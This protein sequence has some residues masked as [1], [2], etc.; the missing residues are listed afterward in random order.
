MSSRAPS[1]GVRDLL[2]ALPEAAVLT[3]V[4][5]VPAFF[6]LATVRIFEEEKAL[7]VRAGALLILAGTIGSWRKWLE[8]FR[9]PVVGAC[10][11]LTLAFALS[12][13]TAL[14][15]RDALLGA[16]LR[17]H[18]LVTWLALV[19]TFVGACQVARSEVG[20]GRLVTA[21][22]VGSVW[23]CLY[24]LMQAAGA[25][26]ISWTDT[27]PGR[28]AGTIGNPLFLAGYL[29][30]VVPIT[31][32]RAVGSPAC[33]ACVL[34]Q[35]A[36][37]AATGSRGPALALGAAVLAGVVVLQIRRW[38][39]AMTLAVGI[40]VVATAAVTWVPELRPAFAGQLLDTSSG[41]GRV[42]VLIWRGIRELMPGSGWR[43]WLGYGPESLRHVFPPHY[44]PEIGRIEQSEA[45]PDRA[46]N[47]MLDSLVGAGL[48][49]VVCEVAFL[50]AVLAAAWRVRDR[51]WRGG[52]LAA[53]VAHILEIQL[54]IATVT[55]RLAFLL[56]AALAVGLQLPQQDDG[57]RGA[58][59]AP[60]PRAGRDV[61]ALV[62]AA[63]VS[64]ASPL[65]ARIAAGL[66]G[67]Q[68][69]GDSQA[70]A[71]Y[72]NA[73]AS[74]PPMLYGAL[75][76]AAVAVAW[77]IATP[78]H[79]R[80]PVWPR[81]TAAGVALVVAYVFPVSASRADVMARAGAAF[82]RSGQVREAVVAHRAAN[83][84]HPG[85]EAY[86]TSL[87]RALVQEA[88]AQDE[89]ARSARF[90]EARAI[91]ER[92]RQRNPHSP[93]P[94]RNL[95]SLQRVR[96]QRASPESR[97]RLLEEADR[98]YQDAT[99]RSPGLPVLWTEWANLDAERR[100]FDEALV[101]L[102]R[103]IELDP[104]PSDP[105]LLRGLV[106]SLQR[107]F[108]PALVDYEQ[109]LA[110]SPAALVALRGRAVALAELGRRQ[111]A[112]AALDEVLRVSPDDSAGRVLRD[113]LAAGP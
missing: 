80:I 33:A 113:R 19:V 24:A 73:L 110:R 34:L 46:H 41:S 64:A 81:A 104:G 37:L 100:R 102:Q 106:F 30:V 53:A 36:A 11:V 85:E 82:E 112:R 12:T 20:R 87:G 4:A 70:L 96:A 25:D 9:H 89:P 23:P 52:L 16:Y 78:G 83:R 17:R 29:V 38:R 86:L 101:K 109:A 79:A 13:L 32:V 74:A 14:E 94:P 40:I 49:G 72:L 93:Y 91:L 45:M 7:L 55:S 18:G 2:D 65:V 54:G 61:Q 88:A 35:L 58:Q 42:R 21:A 43:L 98:H 1:I 66:A 111:E 56:T 92:A 51:R 97:V 108:E 10:G 50:A 69:S 5:A 39:L 60:R 77:T 57:Y 44:T 26:P 6:N 63:G 76:L 31:A 90:D 47:E 3:L 67:A 8:V 84:L 28:A 59:K 75:L 95:G 27:I 15:P 71:G 99:A 48:V 105:W 68:G 107:R 103:A 22:I 62:V